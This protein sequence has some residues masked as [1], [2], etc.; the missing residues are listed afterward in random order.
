V[1]KPRSAFSTEGYFVVGYGENIDVLAIDIIS[2]E[3]NFIGNFVGSYFG[4]PDR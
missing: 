4:H 3:I 2:R 1:S